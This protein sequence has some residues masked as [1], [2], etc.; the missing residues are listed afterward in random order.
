MRIGGFPVATAVLA[1]TAGIALIACGVDVNGTEAFLDDA[2]GPADV[3]IPVDEAPAT[4]E[5]A[6]SSKSS[7]TNRGAKPAVDDGA[8]SEDAVAPGVGSCP[9]GACSPPTSSPTDASSDASSSLPD[10]GSSDERM[11]MPDHDGGHSMGGPAG[12]NPG[13]DGHGMGGPG[14]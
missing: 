11:G 2:G 10:A 13:S 4:P 8:A 1:C 14:H 9:N 7:D 12:G 5:A 3:A 6:S